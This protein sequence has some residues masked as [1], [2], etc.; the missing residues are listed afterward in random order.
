MMPVLLAL[1]FLLISTGIAMGFVR[2]LRGPTFVDRIL[3]FDMVVI[4]LVGL[5]IVLSV[6]WRTEFFVELILILSCLGFFGTVSL[7]YYLDRSMPDPEDPPA[8]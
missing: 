7:M 5:I 3:A 6:H 2:M 1:S 4:S 8:S